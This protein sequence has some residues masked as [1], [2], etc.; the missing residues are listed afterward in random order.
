MYKDRAILFVECQSIDRRMGDEL[1]IIRFMTEFHEALKIS[2]PDGYTSKS[3]IL[4]G[5]SMQENDS[6]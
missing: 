4:N 5:R 1:C 3:I 6:I 2:G